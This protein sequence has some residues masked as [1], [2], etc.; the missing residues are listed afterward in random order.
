MVLTSNQIYKNINV[1][2]NEKVQVLDAIVDVANSSEQIAA[3][4]EE[5]NASVIEQANTFQVVNN[6][7]VELKD[8]A[9]NLNK[10]IDVFIV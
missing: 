10:E 1:V 6:S 3:I 5:V 2:N 8:M 7:A 4:S 9:E